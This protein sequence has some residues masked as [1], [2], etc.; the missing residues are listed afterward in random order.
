MKI[1]FDNASYM[2]KQAEQILKR[3]EQWN[4]KLYLEF[5]GKLFDDYHA[6]RVLPGFNVNGKILLLEKLK[7]KTEL[8][9]CINAADI[10]KNKIRADLGITYDMDVLRLIDNVR[11][12]G[13]YISSIVISQ[14]K[15]QTS[16]VM[17]KNK[18]EQ[19]GEKVYIH[20]PIIGYPMNVD[21]VVSDEGYG[22][23]PY[24]ETTCPLVV[25]TAPGPGSG[26]MATC[27][28][29]I[30]HEYK[31]GINAGYA[32]F[33]TFPIW[34][35]PLNHPVNL[36]YEAATADLNDV[37]VIDPYHLERYGKTAV[38][39]N[40]D[41][42]AFPLVKNILAKIMGT[43]EVYQSPTD[44]GVNMAGYCITD[45]DVVSEAAKQEIVRRYFRTWCDYK[46]GRVEIGAVEKL[47]LIMKQ[48]GITPEYGLAVSPAIEKS[49]QNKCPVMALILHDGSIIIGKTTNV[50]AAASSLVLNSVKKLAGIPDDIHLIAPHVLEPMLMLKEKIL[51]D[52]NPLLSLEEV[53]NALSICAAND[54]S[55]KKCLTKLQD[56]KG[57]EAHSSHMLSKTNESTLKKLGVNVTCTPE[58]SSDDLYYI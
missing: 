48:L 23:N 24:I 38:S 19:R 1:G 50:L 3:V 51:G 49:E 33:E 42:E 37:N 9:I 6:A 25:V 39:Y 40:R 30:Y 22:S 14:Y 43:D 16:A 32:K 2:K 7:E 21:L 47:E 5:G 4:H 41:I 10:E 13:L 34:N 53:L 29:Q 36:A 18:L 58:F 54:P 52:K 26:K 57:C 55:A 20:R 45:N 56:L 31:R 28:S 44:M 15:E 35:I 46:E 8:V 27:L 12:M 17:F 11:R